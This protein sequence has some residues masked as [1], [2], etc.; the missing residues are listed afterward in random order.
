METTQNLAARLILVRKES[1]L[2]P[3]QFALS[4]ECDPSN[5]LKIEKGTL[6]LQNGQIEVLSTKYKIDLN[7]L[8]TGFGD[9]FRSESK[10]NKTAQDPPPGFADIA[11]YIQR[12]ESRTDKIFQAAADAASAAKESAIASKESA[13]TNTIL[14]RILEAQHIQKATAYSD[15]S[16]LEAADAKLARDRAA[17][18]E[19]RKAMGAPTLREELRKVSAQADQQS[20]TSI[21]NDKDS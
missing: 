5:Y 14:S 1:K 18:L 7:W 19:R 12:Y 3:R 16:I 21:Q 15:P 4:I 2:N 13:T 17:A 10:E 9:M 11:D 6:G 8:F 20:K